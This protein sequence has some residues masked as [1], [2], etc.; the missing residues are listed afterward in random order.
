VS[1]SHLSLQ[2]RVNAAIEYGIYFSTRLTKIWVVTYAV[3]RVPQQVVQPP[4]VFSEGIDLLYSSIFP[5]LS[6]FLSAYLI[7]AVFS[8]THHST[9]T[10]LPPHLGQ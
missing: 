4:Q 5:L 1:S 3:Y 10:I 2:E 9:S 7:T 6:D 8:I